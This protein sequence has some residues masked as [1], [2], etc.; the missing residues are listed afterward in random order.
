ME[1]FSTSYSSLAFKLVIFF[2]F[3]LQRRKT[4]SN[5]E[6]GTF[7]LTTKAYAIQASFPLSF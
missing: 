5:T 7:E 6:R 4:N 3:S 2:F 1:L